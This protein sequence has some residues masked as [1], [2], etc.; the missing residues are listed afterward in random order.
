[1]F[2]HV[3][4]AINKGDLIGDF[5]ELDLKILNTN[6]EHIKHPTFGLLVAA[7]DSFILHMKIVMI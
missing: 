4:N 2:L 3:F 7:K 1:M 6:N 5:H